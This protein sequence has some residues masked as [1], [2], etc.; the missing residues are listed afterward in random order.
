MKLTKKSARALAE[1]HY[2][3]F[4]SAII[5]PAIEDTI[6]TDFRGEKQAEKQLPSVL[7]LYQMYDKINIEYFSG[8]L[9]QTRIL[10]SDRMLIAGTFTPSKNEIRIGKKYHRLFPD[11]IED[12]LKH[13]MIHIIN[14][15]HDA[16]FKRI[17]Q[18]IGASLK[19]KTHP[20]L[21]GN[22]RY[23]YYCPNCGT[24]YARRKRLRMAYCGI[25]SK[26]RNFN[27][28]YKLKLLESRVVNKK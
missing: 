9:P 26:N 22:Y 11:E 6:C 19:A 15:N 5:E 8:R 13:E 7:E 18:K 17:A 27:P 23:L 25:C 2:D 20:E 14:L 16:N 10:Y 12:T 1:L 24:E 28:R 21:R 3:L 4:N